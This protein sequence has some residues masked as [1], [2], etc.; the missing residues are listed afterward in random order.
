MKNSFLKFTFLMAALTSLSFF[1]SCTTDVDED[2]F[3]ISECG[4]IE[5]VSLQ[6]D[7]IP[8]FQG[9]CFGCHA[10]NVASGGVDLEDYNSL[11]LVADSGNLLGAIKHDSGYE[12]MPKN[13]NKLDPCQIETIRIW[14]LEGSLNN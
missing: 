14:I 13:D 11:K 1:T 8:V 10:S 9:R 5:A 2:P 6:N 12:A 7:I 3:D 4:V